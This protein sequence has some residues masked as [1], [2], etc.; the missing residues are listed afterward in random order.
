M[1]NAPQIA[2][3][4]SPVKQTLDHA[5]LV[6]RVP[7]LC[8]ENSEVDENRNLVLP[9]HPLVTAYVNECAAL[10][11]PDINLRAARHR[12]QVA[13][14]DYKDRRGFRVTRGIEWSNFGGPEWVSLSAI[15]EVR[16]EARHWLKVIRKL[17]AAKKMKEQQEQNRRSVNR[18][19]LRSMGLAS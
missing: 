4:D 2:K 12:Y 3:H 19:R 1:T 18:H 8:R 16:A 14:Y 10:P 15:I 13:M 11:R 6:E 5:E 7:V 9:R 17:E